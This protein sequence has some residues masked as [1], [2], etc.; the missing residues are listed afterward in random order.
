MLDEFRQVQ[1]PSP[2]STST[3]SNAV[4]AIMK[5]IQKL[6]TI[7]G[8]MEVHA[9]YKGLNFVTNGIFPVKKA[10]FRWTDED[11]ETVANSRG[12]TC[13]KERTAWTKW[14]NEK[15]VV[16]KKLD[17][18]IEAADTDEDGLDAFRQYLGKDSNGA[19]IANNIMKSC[20]AIKRKEKGNDVLKRG[21]GTDKAIKDMEDKRAK[22]AVEG[23]ASRPAGRPVKKAR[24][25]SD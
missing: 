16:G 22:E 21:R 20:A 18:F 5:T 7:T 10:P 12:L 6:P 3:P 14:I 24:A 4:P 13:E 8:P 15:M 1:P 19:D 2:P 17:D 23:V 11:L 25:K 9:F